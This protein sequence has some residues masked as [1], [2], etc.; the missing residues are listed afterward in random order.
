M[1]LLSSNREP[2]LTRKGS[3]IIPSGDWARASFDARGAIPLPFPA[4]KHENQEL[5]AAAHSQVQGQD[6]EQCKHSRGPQGGQEEGEEETP[7]GDQGGHHEQPTAV[8]GQN[9]DGL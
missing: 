3:Q 2:F 7:E 8:H 5:I 9:I 6:M 1:I 4:Q